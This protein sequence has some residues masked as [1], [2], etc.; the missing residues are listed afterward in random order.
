VVGKVLT[1]RS[2]KV[3]TRS[4]FV[5]PPI[6]HRKNFGHELLWTRSDV[7]LW[8][9]SI[10]ACAGRPNV[11]YDESVKQRVRSTIKAVLTASIIIYPLDFEPLSRKR[12]MF[13][14]E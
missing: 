7:A 11:E 13:K 2:Q 4:G 6:A 8:R 9:Q 5:N 1:G 3:C 12:S 10:G 14:V